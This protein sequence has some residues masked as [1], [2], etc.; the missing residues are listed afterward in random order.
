METKI[1]K[2][3]LS[4]DMK[5]PEMM[6]ILIGLLVIV[7]ISLFILSLYIDWTVPYG[8]MFPV[9]TNMA[10]KKFQMAEDFRLY[11]A[12]LGTIA[13]IIVYVDKKIIKAVR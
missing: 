6:E 10:H 7:G 5:I 9:F 1:K 13:C 8:E 4:H 3:G 11:S 12:I 2:T